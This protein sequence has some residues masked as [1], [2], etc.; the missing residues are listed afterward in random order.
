MLTRSII[1]RDFKNGIIVALIVMAICMAAL[2]LAAII[3][4]FYIS[5]A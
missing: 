2:F 5:A 3:E 1:K 4:W